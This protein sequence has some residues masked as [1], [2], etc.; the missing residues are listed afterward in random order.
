MEFE[1]HCSWPA[2]VCIRLLTGLTVWFY[3]LWADQ[4]DEISTGF[5]ADSA[6]LTRSSYA[7]T[8]K[9]GFRASSSGNLG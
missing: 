2:S 6:R 4:S 3:R 9:F 8:P 5:P 7:V 1:F